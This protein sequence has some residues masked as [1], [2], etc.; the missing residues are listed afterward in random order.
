[1][2]SLNPAVPAA[3]TPIVQLDRISKSFA[4][5]GGSQLTVLDQIDLMVQP[6]EFVAIVG[7]SGCGKTTLLRILA[8]LEH[9]DTGQ[10]RIGQPDTSTKVPKTAM[11]FQGDA[12][13]PWRTVLKNIEF[14][15]EADPSITAQQR[16]ERSRKLCSMV[17]LEGFGSS[18]PYEI[19]GGMQQRVNIARALAVSPSVL[20][21][22]EP[23]AA[24][25]AQ[26]REVMQ[27]EL[28]KIWER[29]KKTVVFVTHQMDE[30][31]FLADRVVVLRS[32]P[33]RI[34]LE[35]KVPFARPRSLDLKRSHEF[36]DVVAQIWAQIQHDVLRPG[37][38]E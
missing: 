7:A 23:F 11:V 32:R 27:Q 21:M 33:G 22:D 29:D 16:A 26:T 31:V 14:G 3:P 13:L 1:M 4:K 30:A 8:G 19:S 15:L 24:L 28:L 35:I 20:L 38:T 25:D 12:L 10:M 9:A 37:G 6:G 5:R 2:S 34:G 36:A 17:G 18:Y